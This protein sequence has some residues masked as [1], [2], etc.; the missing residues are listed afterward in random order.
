MTLL[1]I[2]VSY[3]MG[4]AAGH[5]FWQLG[6]VDCDFP[7][8][9]WIAPLL[10]L[11]PLLWWDRTRPLAAPVDLRWP[12]S[13]GFELP[14]PAITGVILLAVGLS[15]AAGM[16]RY[17]GNPVSPCWTDADLAFY[18]AAQDDRAAPTLTL[19]GSVSS[20]PTIKEGRQRLQLEVDSL[21][22]NGEA[23]P[24]TGRVQ[25]STSALP[26]YR[27]G[28]RMEIRGQLVDPPV[29][30]KFDYRA[31]LARKGVHSLLQRPRIE[32][33]PGNDG[34]PLLRG[35]YAL[36]ARGE[37]LLN[38]LLPEPY[39]ALANGML[40][41]IESGIPDELYE[42]FNLTGT[43]HVIVISGSNVA[44]VAGVLVALAARTLGRRR[45][46]W[47]TLIGIALYALL[48]GGD[49]AVVRAS[50]MGGLVVVATTLRRQSTALI[51]L[52]FACWVM[53]LL[54]PLTLWDVGFQLSSAAT[55]GLILFSPGMTA[56][57]DRLWPGFGQG[58]H[59]TGSGG[60]AEAGGSL[61]RGLIQDGLL[62]TLAANVTT[63]P[64]VV[65][66]FERLSVVSPLTNLLISPA[67]P[68]IM[69]WGGLGVILG[70]MGLW[71]LAQVIL[72]IPYLSLW[73]TV[74]MVQWTAAL[75]GANLEI[76]NYS[77]T[78]LILTYATLGLIRW[79]GWLRNRVE[80]ARQIT[81]NG[82][83]LGKV[84]GNGALVGLS[85]A[86]FLV[87]RIVLTQPDG[88]L[89]IH[90]LDV[91]QG[92]G[93]FI[94]TPS[95]RQML[96]DGGSDPARLFSELGEVMPFWDRSL[97][98]LILSHPDLDHMG[99]QLTLPDRYRVDGAVVSAVTLDH[100]DGDGWEAM[101][102]ATGVPITVQGAGGWID[103]GDGVA[104][105]TLWPADESSARLSGVDGDDKNERSLV[106]KLVYGEFEVLLTGDAG[107]PAERV[108]VRQSALQ[109]DI[110]KVGHHGSN[111]STDPGFVATVNPSIAVIQVG[112]N[113]YGHPT[114]N[115]LDTLAG[116]LIL[117]NDLNGRVHLWSDGVQLWI[118]GER[119]INFR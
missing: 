29:F 80:A 27:Y 88:Y 63:L 7:A 111:G 86:A 1:Y 83:W 3:M 13:A 93:I 96:I 91:G 65:Y 62:V 54:N 97:D 74:S 12:R 37:A 101:L 38:R 78:A 50:F 114:Q 28:Q 11:P 61:L 107:I 102:A 4:V 81:W 113:R 69:L 110:L 18:N 42:Q 116:R 109:A 56:F 51:S 5:W 34:N 49:A 90:F 82:E 66:Y 76:V 58:G 15:A 14:R 8:W 16:L 20:Y 10:A 45:A 59:L 70:V 115:V 77:S 98:L 40:L 39:A 43:S 33:L 48:V 67:Q 72:W 79:R 68:F 89:H 17:A 52:S 85:V 73:W 19:I 75:P 46:L 99:A 94:Q 2:A 55:A 9:L 41:G 53:T 64:L 23:R 118:E 30:D 35:I 26:R 60:A 84:A 57:F 95:G 119:G 21:I 44:I 24:V 105:W 103:L 47:P 100:K 92:D 112:E 106:Q 6:I 36:R 71:P 31:Y 25:I 32:A 87:W 22:Q 108:L 104:L 117:R